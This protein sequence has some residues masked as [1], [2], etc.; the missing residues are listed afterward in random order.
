[1]KEGVNK[2]ADA[3]VLVQD[4]D[5]VDLANGKLSV[6]NALQKQRMK[7]KGKVGAVTYF[8]SALLGAKPK[9]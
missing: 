4:E 5:L 7:L 1:M 6:Q 8:T 2:N 3:V 9:L